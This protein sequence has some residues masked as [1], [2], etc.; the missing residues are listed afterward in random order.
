MTSIFAEVVDLAAIKLGQQLD[1]IRSANIKARA[2][3]NKI[4]IHEAELLHNKA[5]P[6]HEYKRLQYLIN[7]TDK[8]ISES[9]N[10]LEIG[11]GRCY[12]VRSI[13]RM[14]Q[15]VSIMLADIN[16]INPNMLPPNVSSITASVLDLPIEDR[17]YDIAVCTEVLEHLKPEYFDMA[18]AEIRRVSKNYIISLPFLEK[19]PMYK[20]HYN[21]FDV[22][23]ILSKFTDERISVLLKPNQGCPIIV[24]SSFKQ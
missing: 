23:S 11:P 14:H 17:Q 8:Y 19:Q 2:K 13:G 12:Y 4:S 7:Q 16:P 18:L 15:D 1:F 24:L 22:Q 21:R 3:V 10:L 9:I 20:G 6:L 5:F